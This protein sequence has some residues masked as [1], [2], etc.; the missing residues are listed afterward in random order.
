MW[1]LDYKFHEESDP[2]CPVLWTTPKGPAW[3]PLCNT[4]LDEVKTRML[5]IRIFKWLV[6]AHV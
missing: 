4:L 3:Q 2:V 5:N 1:I 6:T